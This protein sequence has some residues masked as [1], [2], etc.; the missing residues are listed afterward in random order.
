[1][2]S[3]SN[4]NSSDRYSDRNSSSS[5]SGWGAPSNG[6]S[7]SVKPFSSMQSVAGNDPWGSINKQQQPDSNSW[8]RSMDHQSQDRYDRTYNERKSSSQYMDGPSVG[9]S[10]G[11]RPGSF[12]TS[13]RPQDRYNSNTMSSRFDGGRF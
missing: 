6:P 4:A 3:H 7:S 12:V 10:S 9:S 13:S 11:N 1:M 2:D 5:S 8:G